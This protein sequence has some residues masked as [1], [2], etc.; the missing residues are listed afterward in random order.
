MQRVEVEPVGRNA[1]SA[2]RRVTLPGS[3]PKEV[4]S[5]AAAVGDAGRRDISPRTATS[6]RSVTTVREQVTCPRTVLRR[7]RNENL[8]VV[9]FF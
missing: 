7:R 3:V 6:H 5:R 1:E 8:A 4:R 2:E 9:R